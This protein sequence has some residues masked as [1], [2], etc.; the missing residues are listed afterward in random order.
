MN[1]D[2][3]PPVR[4]DLSVNKRFDTYGRHSLII[5]Y[6][7]SLLKPIPSSTEKDL[8]MYAKYGGI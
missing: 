6:L 4:S 3:A 8:A 7:G 1:V 2:N 5:E